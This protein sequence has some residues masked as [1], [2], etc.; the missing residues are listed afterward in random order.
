M[1]LADPDAH[2]P[3][4]GLVERP[5]PHE[6]VF[7]AGAQILLYT[8]GAIEAR[9]RH[10]RFY[11]LA[12][13]AFLLKDED[14]ERALEALKQDLVDHGDAPLHADAAMLLLRPRESKINRC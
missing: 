9:D 6:I 3:P 13:R 10:G 7:G 14:P 1:S 8:D 5:E 12:E 11:P 2:A 4:L